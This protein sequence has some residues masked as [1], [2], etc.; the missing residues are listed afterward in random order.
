[1]LAINFICRLKSFFSS[2]F[3]FPTI[4]RNFYL[5]VHWKLNYVIIKLASSP[6]LCLPFALRL[7]ND[8][9][10][11]S[12]VRLLSEHRGLLSLTPH[13]TFPKSS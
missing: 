11:R 6:D 3:V 4:S 13:A 1:M 5:D 12:A 8:S 10:I 7:G 9:S 2:G